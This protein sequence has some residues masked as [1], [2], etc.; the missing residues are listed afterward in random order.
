LVEEWDQACPE[1]NDVLMSILREGFITL[2]N[3]VRVYFHD[4]VFGLTTNLGMKEV[5]ANKNRISLTPVDKKVTQAD[6]KAA[7]DKVLKQNTTRA[8]RNRINEIVYYV[9]LTY[10]E[11]FDVVTR[12]VR[13]LNHRTMNDP[14]TIC[15]IVVDHAA[16]KFI[17]DSGL[18]GG[19]DLARVLQILE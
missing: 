18:E 10:D 11:M 12:E 8:F 5:E 19:G 16:K 4:C 15:T 3:G 14:E 17:L 7:V 13:R 6:I 9:P 1:F 2:G